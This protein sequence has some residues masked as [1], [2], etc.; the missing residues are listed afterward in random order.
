M[1]I[2]FD[3][4]DVTGS[5]KFLEEWL[6]VSKKSIMDYIVNS[7]SN[8][9]VDDFLEIGSIDIDSLDIE[10]ISY[11]ASHVTTTIDNLAFMKSNGL[12]DLA[13][14]LT[15]D[16]PLSKY[17][18]SHNLVFDITNKRLLCNETEYDIDY[19][20]EGKS[21]FI[22]RESIEGRVDSIAH[23]VCYDNQI[24]AFFTMEGDKA[25][26]T[27]IHLRPEFLVNIS[28]LCKR[29]IESPW[30]KKATGFVIEYE[31]HFNSFEWFS[32]YDNESDYWD[33]SKDRE[34]HKRW[35]VEKSLNLLRDD[36]YYNHFCESFAYMKANY[37]IPWS[38]VVNCR[39]IV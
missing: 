29:D 22:D 39:E 10:N 35:L 27:Q 16:S 15:L 19:Y 21:K 25:Y 18:A 9:D 13:T 32:F 31:E 2:R 20:R 5:L 8:I 26:L 37:V 36:F 4:R 28:N 34:R 1:S 38:N 3:L 7:Q 30:A 23:K 6:G 11:I 14:L 24:S 33:D 12:M 17:L